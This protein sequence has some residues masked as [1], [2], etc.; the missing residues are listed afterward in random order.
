MSKIFLRH[1]L[2]KKWKIW[3]KS[4]LNIENIRRTLWNDLEYIEERQ[5][6]YWKDM[7][8]MEETQVESLKNI[9]NMEEK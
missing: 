7:K 9:E 6:E 5:V 3:K 2:T 8:N 1:T 4:N